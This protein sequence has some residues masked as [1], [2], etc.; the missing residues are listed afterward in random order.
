MNRVH[1]VQPYFFKIY[2]NIIL[3]SMLRHPRWFLLS[4]F[5]TEILNSHASSISS[6]LIWTP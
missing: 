3:P 2:F 6:S 1:N 5:L 4:S